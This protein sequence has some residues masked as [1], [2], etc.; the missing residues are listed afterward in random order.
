MKRRTNRENFQSHTLVWNRRRISI[1]VTVFTRIGG[2]TIE[3]RVIER[4][5]SIRL[6]SPTDLVAV[7]FTEY[8]FFEGAPY[9]QSK[10][11]DVEFLTV[12]DLS[13]TNG[14]SKA[15]A[16]SI[17]RLVARRKLIVGLT[18]REVLLGINVD[19][20]FSIFIEETEINRMERGRFNVKQ[21]SP[22]CRWR[23]R[24]SLIDRIRYRR[25]STEKSGRN[26]N[27]KEIV[28]S[29]RE[30]E[31]RESLD[32]CVPPEKPASNFSLS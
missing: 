7:N 22:L 27:V 13:L 4:G 16:P 30:A 2:A 23:I 9:Q 11:R 14:E 24:A 29:D 5:N 3:A 10:P 8:H 32:L 18:I 26:W 28:Y 31:T 21:A 17:R 15:L 1:S 20:G 12:V 25:E 6:L 19:G